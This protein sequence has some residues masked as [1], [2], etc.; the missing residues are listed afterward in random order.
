MKFTILSRP[1]APGA[2]QEAWD[3]AETTLRAIAHRAHQARRRR[4]RGSRKSRKLFEQRVVI[5][6]LAREFS[7]AMEARL[8]QQEVGELVDVQITD[9]REESKYSTI[10]I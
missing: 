9:W 3:R 2:A 8:I 10:E 7:L 4:P 1:Q 6:A 5:R